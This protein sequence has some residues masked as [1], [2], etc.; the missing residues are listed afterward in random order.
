MAKRT[1]EE[2]EARDELTTEIKV[3]I[4]RRFACF[5]S[6]R[7]VR[8][9][10]EDEYGLELSGPAVARY[11][12][13]NASGEASMGQELKELFWTTRKRFEEE[14]E[15]IGIVH[16]AYR[17]QKMDE[18]ERK[19]RAKEDF[20]SA[21]DLLKQAAEELGGAYEKGKGIT[22]QTLQKAMDELAAAVVAEVKDP[23]ALAR[24]EARWGG[25]TEQDSLEN[26]IKNNF[27]V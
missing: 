3:F 7:E 23:E 14:I 8:K 17:L 4:V 20:K 25:A 6:T 27:S 13:T 16:K 24:I 19:A 12:A 26:R 10:V 9:A 21:S 22:L 15:D 18:M 1:K 5:E 11:N 2:R